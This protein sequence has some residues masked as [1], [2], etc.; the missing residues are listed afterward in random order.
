[1]A[2]K[3]RNKS[4]RNGD[5]TV[6]SFAKALWASRMFVDPRLGYGRENYGK[7]GAAWSL[8]RFVQPMTGPISEEAT[9]G[10]EAASGECGLRPVGSAWTF[11]ELHRRASFTWEAGCV[12]RVCD[13]DR[14][15]RS[16]SIIARAKEESERATALEPSVIEA[17]TRTSVH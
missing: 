6:M 9:R 11:P 12:E 16:Q 15:L 4:V 7:T 14:R 17:H 2:E 8:T 5:L 10:V 3:T 1:M 13:W